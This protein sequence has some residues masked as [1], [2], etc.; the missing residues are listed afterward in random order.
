[1]FPVPMFRP[2]HSQGPGPNCWV[3]AISSASPGESLRRDRSSHSFLLAAKMMPLGSARRT[4]PW[5]GWR[6]SFLEPGGGALFDTKAAGP[7]PPERLPPI[8]TEREILPDEAVGG[9]PVAGRNGC[10]VAVHEIAD[11]R[12]QGI[13]EE[14]EN[15]VRSG[16]GILSG[17]K[18]GSGHLFKAR[19]RLHGLQVFRQKGRQALLRLFRLDGDLFFRLPE[20]GFLQGGGIDVPRDRNGKERKEGQYDEDDAKLQGITLPCSARR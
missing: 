20:R 8:G 17:G 11:V 5:N 16:D 1:M 14:V 2:L 13:P 18:Q 4:I 10:P 6:D 7:P 19:Q 3:R 12:V 15:G 9:V